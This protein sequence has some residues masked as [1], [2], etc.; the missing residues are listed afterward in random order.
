MLD[1]DSYSR[2]LQEALQK[3]TKISTSRSVKFSR[4]SLNETEA[5]LNGILP[6]SKAQLSAL[7]AVVADVDANS[8][9]QE[10][11]IDELED[12]LNNLEVGRRRLATVWKTSVI[13]GLSLSGAIREILQSVRTSL[14]IR[15]AF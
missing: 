10:A 8:A 1:L 15:V 5:A 6:A 7:K 4:S 13:W 14:I 12:R 11:R 2:S 9:S 3:A